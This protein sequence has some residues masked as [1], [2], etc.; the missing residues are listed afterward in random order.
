MN[1]S[2]LIIVTKEVRNFLF[3]WFNKNW[4]L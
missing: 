2:E 1:L 3:D 4:W